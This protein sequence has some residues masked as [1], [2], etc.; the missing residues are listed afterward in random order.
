M[1][2]KDEIFEAIGLCG[3]D[4]LTAK[5][6]I[7]NFGE[8]GLWKAINE[9]TA[10]N[11]IFSRKRKNES[12]NHYISTVYKTETAEEEKEKEQKKKMKGNE[13][14]AELQGALLDTIAKFSAGKVLDE[15]MPLVRKKCVEEFGM[16]PVVHEIKV[17]G[18][19]TAK[20]KADLPPCFKS[21]LAYAVNGNPVMMTGPAGTGKGFLARQ[22]AKA[23]GA[24]FFEVNAVKN[25]YE[26]T[27]FVDANSRF[28][29]TPFYDACKAVAEGKKAVFLF[30]EMDCSDPEVLKVFNEALSSLEFTFPN[31]EHLTFDDLIILCACNTFGTGSDEM[32]CGEQLDASTLDR[33]VIVRVD[34]NRKI[35]LS[36]AQGDEELVDFIDSF[37][38]Q[39]EK[40]GLAFVVSYRSI[41]RIVSMRGVLPLKQVMKECLVKS[42]A[43]DD[44]RNI[45]SNMGEMDNVYYKACKGEKVDWRKQ[46]EQQ[47]LELTA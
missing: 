8:K 32:Y 10:E 38:N 44:L 20:I 4:G 39:T 46:E 14:G 33:F 25:A 6:L 18:K 9:L 2:R 34:Y 21:I 42:M 41:K 1:S 22:V 24:E 11:K 37:R 47:E 13:L 19:E 45:L 28:V 43:K 26:L 30:D 16:T 17:N 5:D 27:G 15:V 3:A 7:G 29:R 40:N 36:I 12:C 23:T 35:E 31:D